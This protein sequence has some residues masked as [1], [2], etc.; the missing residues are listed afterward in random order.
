MYV[1]LYDYRFARVAPLPGL[2]VLTSFNS[3][4]RLDDVI[5]LSNG[6]K[7]VPP[8]M[9]DIVAASPYIQGCVMFGHQRTEVGILVEPTPSEQIDIDDD[10][11]VAQFRN[12]I[13]CVLGSFIALVS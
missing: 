12:K 11:Q 5:V 3:V 7:T 9:E 6:E 10:G 13:W 2:H 8:P 1:V 4:G